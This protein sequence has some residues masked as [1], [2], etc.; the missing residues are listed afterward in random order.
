MEKKKW[1]VKT[2]EKDYE[3]KLISS[4]KIKIDDEEFKIAPLRHKSLMGVIT[5]YKLPVE[6][7]EIYL[8]YN[9]NKYI[10]VVDGQNYDTEKDYTMIENIPKWTYIFVVLNAINFF[11]GVI[12]VCFAFLGISLTFKICTSN[13]NII[14]KI[15]L[16]LLT[17]LGMIAIVLVIAILL[18]ILLYV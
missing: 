18:N 15:F 17:L 12:G 11:N 16:S 4:N 7:H 1:I 9:F 5:E 14:S 6:E 8:V 13:M 10:L 2:E 3:I